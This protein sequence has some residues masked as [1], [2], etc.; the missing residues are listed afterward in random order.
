M[1]EHTDFVRMNDVAA[2]PIAD[3][4]LAGARRRLLSEDLETGDWTALVEVPAGFQADAGA[5]S[6]SLELL[7]VEGDVVVGGERL[8]ALGWARAGS[9]AGLGMIASDGGAHILWMTGHANDQAARIVDT[10]A[11]PWSAGSHGGP[12]GIAAKVL[13]EDAPVSLVVANVPRYDSGPEFHECPE[14]LFVLEGDVTGNAGTMTPGSYFWRPAY[15]THGPYRSESGLLCFLRGH[16]ELH[17][18]WIENEH[19]TVEDNNA[20]AATL[21]RAAETRPKR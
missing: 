19:A 12:P 7:V 11:L 6:S 13:A 9:A 1:R 17:A 14:E 4:P 3:G 20:H 18:H 8:G 2:E 10:E 5:E 15:V 21:R 16:G